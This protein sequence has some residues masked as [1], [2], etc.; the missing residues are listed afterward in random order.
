MVVGCFRA[1]P[2]RTHFAS[3]C[4]TRTAPRGCCRRRESP[5]WFPTRCRVASRTTP[6]F[7]FGGNA[8][9]SDTDL[10]WSALLGVICGF[11]FVMNFANG[12]RRTRTF[13]VSLARAPHMPKLLI[14]GLLTGIR[15]LAYISRFIPASSFR[16]GPNYASLPDDSQSSAGPPASL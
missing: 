1:P 3:R 14:G 15:G 16:L 12:F 2:T 5:R 8:P 7:A 13:F 4:R 10:L 6:L 11:V 9:F